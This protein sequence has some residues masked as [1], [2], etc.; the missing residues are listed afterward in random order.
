MKNHR[1]KVLVSL[2]FIA[3]V[4]S[5]VSHAAPLAF[6]AGVG[7]AFALERQWRHSTATP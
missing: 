5:M 2:W 3:A 6:I 7:L 1:D 4:A